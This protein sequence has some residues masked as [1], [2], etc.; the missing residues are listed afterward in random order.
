MWQLHCPRARKDKL[1]KVGQRVCRL[2]PAR[3][4][5]SLPGRVQADASGQYTLCCSWFMRIDAV[6]CEIR[7]CES[8]FTPVRRGLTRSYDKRPHLYFLLT[9]ASVT[10]ATIQASRVLLTHRRHWVMPLCVI[11]PPSNPRALFSPQATSFSFPLFPVYFCHLSV[12]IMPHETPPSA[13]P[14]AAYL[15]NRQRFG[16][17]PRLNRFLNAASPNDRYSGRNPPEPSRVY[18]SHDRY[19]LTYPPS[20]R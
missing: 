7:G 13:C 12:F 20:D 5:D 9:P 16:Q 18:P 10:A 1:R 4:P 8:T 2:L 17:Q 19:G 3:R 14:P 6:K 11:P 15:K